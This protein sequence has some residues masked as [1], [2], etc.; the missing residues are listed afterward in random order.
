M[1]KHIVKIRINQNK[2]LECKTL[3][4]II[5]II[6]GIFVLLVIVGLFDLVE[7]VHQIPDVNE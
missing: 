4:K 3:N 6:L 2:I 5:K 7:I 1:H